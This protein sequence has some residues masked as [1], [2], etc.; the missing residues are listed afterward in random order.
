MTLL[1]LCRYNSQ[2]S[3]LLKYAEYI[4]RGRRYI[5]LKERSRYFLRCGTGLISSE[6]SVVLHG[7][8]EENIF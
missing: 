7:D 1:N 5:L 8:Y 4:L 6:N 2:I 3:R